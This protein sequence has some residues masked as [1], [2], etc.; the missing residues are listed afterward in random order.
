MPFS[1]QTL[2]QERTRFRL[3]APS[4]RSVEL[5]LTNDQGE[6]QIVDMPVCGEG[7]RERTHQ[8]A[9]GTR[10][11]Y[12]ID[13]RLEVPDPASRHNPDD[14]HGASEVIDPTAF[15]WTDD[16]WRGRPWSEAVLYEVHVGA[17][18]PE[19]TFAGVERR[20]DYLAALGVTAIELMPIAEFPGKRN[21]GYDGVLQFAPEAS[22]GRPEDLK[23]LIAA[24]HARGLMVMLDVVYNHFGPE[25]NYLNA[26][27]S[28]FFTERH[29]TDWG[30]AINFDGDGARTV[31][32]FFI[33]NALY[34]LEEFHFDGLRFDAVHAIIDDSTPHILVELA[35]AVRSGPGAQ[36]EIHLVL[37]NDRNEA[38]YLEYRDGA[39]HLYNAQ[40]N[41][42][43][44]HAFHV[45]LTGEKDGYYADYAS[46]TAAKLA[47][48]LTEGFA[49]QAEPS[50]YRG[51][52]PRGEPSRHLPPLAF[53]T[54]LQNHDQIGNRAFGERLTA[55]TTPAR[56]RAALAVWL[57]APSPPMLFMGE[58]FGAT[59]P[60]LFFCDFGPELA[61]AVTEGRRREFARFTRFGGSDGENVI[62]D[63]N[64]PHTF[65]R[66]K[67]DWLS[68]ERPEHRQWLELYGKLLALRREHVVPRLRGMQGN[69]GRYSVISDSTLQAAWQ[70]GDGSSLSTV[71]N[72]SSQKQTAHGSPSG[73]LLHC[74][75]ASAAIAF[76][77]G[78][79]PPNAAAIYL[80]RADSAL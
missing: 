68:L 27:A 64:H 62:P 44:H 52:S 18:S 66:S 39:P 17:F 8:A 69:S 58:E 73:E 37:E 21:W 47:R 50:P 61:Q 38:R 59:T 76:N 78:E 74:E 33:D 55:L 19:G 65:E 72:L 43:E 56:L 53:V 49:Y 45:L 57:L 23:R 26:Y 42:D 28:Q 13:G 80:S 1:A 46:E 12:R 6:W 54:F 40:W 4:A 16:A 70:L 51:G 22:Y 31:R 9:A 25:G 63:P 34:W 32:D 5:I 24:A 3:W 75:P 60:F 14:V 11:R 10:Y 20:L 7:W 2:D 79:L 30:A 77:D 29:H 67:L 35:Q 36:R 71:L 41:D 48:C 15:E